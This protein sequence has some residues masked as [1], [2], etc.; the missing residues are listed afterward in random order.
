MCDVFPANLEPSRAFL[1]K[2]DV[3]TR[4]Q[5]MVSTLRSLNIPIRLSIGDRTNNC[6]SSGLD[7]S[8]YF[9]D[10]KT[11]VGEDEN[12]HEVLA[13]TQACFNLTG[14]AHMVRTKSDA[15]TY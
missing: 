12:R 2:A 14:I 13:P 6:P 9:G 8:L 3:L 7:G 11:F 5:T 1:P 4:I 10:Y 15:H